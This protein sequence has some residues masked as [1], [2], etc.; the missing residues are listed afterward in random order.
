MSVSVCWTQQ[1]GRTG[2]TIGESYDGGRGG[3]HGSNS[4]TRRRLGAAATADE[5]CQKEVIVV[6]LV[7]LHLHGQRRRRRKMGG[8]LALTSPDRCSGLPVAIVPCPLHQFLSSSSS[9]PSVRRHQRHCLQ[10]GGSGTAVA[11][12]VLHATCHQRFFL[13]PGS[14]ARAHTHTHATTYTTVRWT[15]FF[16]L[17]P[18]GE[19]G[20]Q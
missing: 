19:D 11:D 17:V 9:S 18:L 5:S 2:C 20:E 14:R 7:L 15:G 1:A 13:N 8:G 4:I 12:L 6:I 3:L 10:V 16:F